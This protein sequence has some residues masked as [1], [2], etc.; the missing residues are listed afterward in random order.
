MYFEKIKKSKNQKIG[1]VFKNF[2]LFIYGGVN[3]EPYKKKFTDLIGRKVDS[4][5]LYP[6][7]EGFFAYQNTQ[8]SKD[9][10][11]LLDSGVFYEFISVTDF[12]S[13]CIP[14]LQ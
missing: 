6:A 8:K 5:E 4:I 14:E 9:L 10:L 12:N 3:F 7:S 13:K 1:D 2:S 11:L